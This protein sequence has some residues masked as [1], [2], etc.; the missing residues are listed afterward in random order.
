MKIN[1]TE[2]ET[3]QLKALAIRFGTTPE[4]LVERFVSDL[5]D[6]SRCGG[7][8]EHMGARGYV[9]RAHIDISPHLTLEQLSEMDALYA[10]ASAAKN[11]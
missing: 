6:S 7:S 4:E 3:C 5:T 8:D 9:A 11:R 1:I 2:E 10:R